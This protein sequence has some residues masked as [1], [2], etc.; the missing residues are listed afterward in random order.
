MV[1]FERKKEAGVFEVANVGT[2]GLYSPTVIPAYLSD[3]SWFDKSCA[4]ANETSIDLEGFDKYGYDKDGLDRAGFGASA[5]A[6]RWYY[7][8]NDDH[9][10][11][12]EIRFLEVITR[13]TVR[14]YEE[15]PVVLEV[16]VWD[17]LPT[18]V[19]IPAWKC[20]AEGDLVWN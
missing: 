3:P 18:D 2:R 20:S 11:D 9:L 16:S 14:W 12:G 19:K 8:V 6:E 1:F 15:V 5:Y 17:E 10:D 7:D 13:Y 4:M